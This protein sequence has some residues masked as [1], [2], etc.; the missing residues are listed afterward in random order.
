MTS[1]D[2]VWHGIQPADVFQRLDTRETGLTAPEAARRLVLQ[3]P[4]TLKEGPRIN[5]L[6]LF[7]G[8]FRSLLVGILIAAGI[9]SG[10]LGEWID[11]VAILT[12]VAL[13]AIIGF[14]QE[15]R[16]ERS[17]A[18]LGRMTAPRA[19]VRRDGQ[20]GSIAAAEIVAGDVLILEA[21]D[22]VA[23]DAR[24][25]QS[26]SLRCVESALTGES[27]AVAKRIDVLEQPDLPLGDRENMVFLGT[28]VAA[29]KGRSGR[30][31]DGDADGTGVGSQA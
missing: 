21:G 17:I 12:I 18:A 27:D 26:A 3:G 5:P 19:K 10:L 20:P 11:S 31:G 14:F 30:G 16:A 25:V 24:L 22:L 1:P 29:G 28:T 6:M 9:V 15:Y 23:A 7:L 13:N 4:N 2:P 8:Q